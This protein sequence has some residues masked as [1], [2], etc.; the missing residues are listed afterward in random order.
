MHSPLAHL[1]FFFLKPVFTGVLLLAGVTELTDTACSLRRLFL[2][3]TL[4]F[5]L[6]LPVYS[7]LKRQ[8]W[9]SS[10]SHVLRVGGKAEFID[11]ILPL[12]GWQLGV[13][14]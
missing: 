14:K 5:P 12:Q 2:L 10:A 11:S 9:I 7:T 3:R 13:I 4:S 6:G 8:A 1:F